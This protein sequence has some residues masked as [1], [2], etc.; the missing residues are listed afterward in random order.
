MRNKIVIAV[1]LI[2]AIIASS[3]QAFAADMTILKKGETV[4]VYTIY[5]YGE[6]NMTM[7]VTVLTNPTVASLRNL[8]VPSEAWPMCGAYSDGFYSTILD[9][10]NNKSSQLST[11]LSDEKDWSAN[12]SNSLDYYRVLF[13]MALAVIVIGGIVWIVWGR[14]R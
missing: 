1:I 9:N 14:N 8:D 11:E 13:F 4:T 3:A 2:V 5:N 12:V 6:S 7:D 10:A